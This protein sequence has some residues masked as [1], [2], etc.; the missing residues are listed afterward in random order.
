MLV[1]S[2]TPLRISLFGGGTDYPRWYQ[3]YG[4]EVLGGAISAYSHIYI[5]MSS[6]FFDKQFRVCYSKLEEVSDYNELSHPAVRA[7]IRYVDRDLRGVEILYS[8]DLPSRSGLGSSSSFTVGLLNALYVLTGR[9]V[10][11]RSLYEAAIDVEQNKLRESV[12]VQDQILTTIG[13]FNRIKISRSGRITV[14][15]LALESIGIS[16]LEDYLLLVPTGIPRFASDIAKE[17][18]EAMGDKVPQHQALMGMVSLGMRFLEN[19]DLNSLGSLLH[20]GW[21]IKRELSSKI[22]NEFVDR[23]YERARIEG[24]LGGKLLG[25]GGGGFLLLLA[26]PSVHRKISEALAPLKITRVKFE[27]HGSRARKIKY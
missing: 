23:I 16:R 14:A 26:P 12:G 17:Q 21:M 9:R 25:A 4:G 20:D 19:G 27:R 7:C 8:G 6:E 24:A 13:G 22:T 15:S 2:L 5:R 18:I 1:L 3:N 10:G 11:K